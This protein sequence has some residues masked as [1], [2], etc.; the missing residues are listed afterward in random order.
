LAPSLASSPFCPTQNS[1]ILPAG[2]LSPI[3]YLETARSN[4]PNYSRALRHRPWWAWPGGSES[5]HREEPQPLRARRPAWR[6][7]SSAGRREHPSRPAVPSDSSATTASPGTGWSS[8]T[9]GVPTIRASSVLPS[10]TL[11]RPGLGSPV[12]EKGLF[13]HS[14]L[15]LLKAVPI[16]R[17][18]F[19]FMKSYFLKSA[20][21]FLPV[22]PPLASP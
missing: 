9:S 5:P 22:S 13:L 10:P 21:L 3:N 6:V 17:S 15:T 2:K 20:C 11:Q 12:G 19:V 4:F 18:R 14:L 1:K 16:P 8:H 7:G